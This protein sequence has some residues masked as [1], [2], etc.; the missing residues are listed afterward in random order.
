[1]HER[2]EVKEMTK[3]EVKQMARTD[4]SNM[5]ERKA[6]NKKANRDKVKIVIHPEF[7]GQ[8]RLPEVILPVIFDEFKKQTQ[9]NP[10]RR[11]Y[12]PHE[13]DCT[14]ETV[15]PVEQRRTVK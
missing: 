8:K 3:I 13:I 9:Y 15:S 10:H 11:Q 14:Q 7:I 12:F 6:V 2:I 1:M 4:K 5:A